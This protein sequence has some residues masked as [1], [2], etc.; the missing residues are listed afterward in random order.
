[1]GKRSWYVAALLIASL[2]LFTGG[3]W[4]KAA[5]ARAAKNRPVVAVV[6]KG[7]INMWWEVVRKGAAKA[8]AERGL[9]MTW[10][11]PEVETDREKQIQA[12]EDALIK[13]AS[14]VVF[15]PNDFKAMVRPVEKIKAA[16]IPCVIV[17][18][19]VATEQ[20]DAFVGTDNFKGGADAAKI[21]GR[22]LGGRGSVLLIKYVQNSASTDARAAGFS[23]TLRKE[24]PGIRILSEQYTL[25]TVEDARQKTVDLLTRF[26]DAGGVFAVNHPSSVGAYKAIENQNLAGKVK[27]VGFDSD[28][29]LLEGISKGE[30]LAVI[31]QNPF[32]IG[33]SGMNAAADLL[34]GKKVRRNVPV[35]SMIVEKSNLDE[36]KKK[37]PEALGL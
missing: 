4:K 24:F 23:E 16:G 34:E 10:N 1:M 29:V 12:V 8:A 17:D 2:I 6:P 33:Y 7:T 13:K 9:G 15:G 31:A 20:Y 37:F 26:P 36:M 14:A 27:F 19:P 30:V 3:V 5:H 35:P 21:L 18:S 32:E 11:G 28:P 25:G 22:A